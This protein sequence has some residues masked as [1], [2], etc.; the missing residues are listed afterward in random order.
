LSYLSALK[1]ILR[2]DTQV[3][4]DLDQNGQLFRTAFLNVFLTGCF[5]G[6]ANLLHTR[7]ILREELAGGFDNPL[8][9]AAVFAVLTL[10]GI[11]SI[12]LAHAGFSLLLWALSKG[13]RGESPFFPVYLYTGAA[14]AP[15]WLGLPFI[16]LY[17]KGIW[18][19][20]ALL[21]GALGLAWGAVTMIRS[22]MAGQNFTFLRASLAL[23]LTAIFIIS[24][25]I[26]TG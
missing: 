25:R 23:A 2:L 15:L 17:S 4:R 22:I 26:I 16:Y 10:A 9:G 13:L 8:L 3:Y 7:L 21:L 18:P 14:L 5:Y 11:A 24:F 19:V 12:F 6:L 20:A 1:K